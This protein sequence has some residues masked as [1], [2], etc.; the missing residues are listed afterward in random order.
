MNKCHSP[1]AAELCL[2]SAWPVLLQHLLTAQSFAGQVIP[3]DAGLYWS[4]QQNITISIGPAN[5][6]SVE[7]I[8]EAWLVLLCCAAVLSLLS[9]GVH[10]HDMCP[11]LKPRRHAS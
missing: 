11:K 9:A 4:P 8:R 1:Q 2:A 5:S 10:L 7:R 3:D 6:S